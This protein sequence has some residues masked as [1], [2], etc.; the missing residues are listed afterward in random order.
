M[1]VTSEVQIV[2]SALAKLGVERISNMNDT[3]TRARIMNEQY[4]KIRNELLYSHPW[5]FAI[6]RAELAST[7]N[8]PEFGF[9]YEFTLPTDCLR[10]LETDLY[11]PAEW[12]VEG[13]FIYSHYDTLKIKYIREETDVTKFTPGFVELLALKLAVDTCYSLVQNASLKATLLDEYKMKVREVRA[14]NAQEGEGTRFYADS[15]LNS[16]A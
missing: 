16:R 10:V 7:V 11:A 12:K 9:E 3:T 6:K 4:G 5:S 1:G 8:T 2:N 15:W 14:F 13:R